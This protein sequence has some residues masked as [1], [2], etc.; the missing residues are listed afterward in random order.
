MPPKQKY[1]PGQ[2]VWETTLRCNLKC[3]HCGS[4]AGKA[5]PNELST[6]EAIRLC[7]DLAELDTKEVCLMGGE[8]FLRKDWHIIAKK[9][10][11][12]NMKL[13]V[14]SNGYNI[15][16]DIISKLVKLEPHSVSTSLDGSTAKTHDYIRGVNGS[17]DKVL[18]YISLSK[19]ADL[20]TTVITTVSKLNF[21]ELPEIRD[22]LLNKQ[23]AWQ[24]QVATPEGR[25]TGKNALSKEEYYSVALFIA[26]MKNKYSP[27]EIPVAAAH[28]FGY[29]SQHLPWLGLYPGWYG[30]QAGISVLS[31]KSN[32]DIIGCLSVPESEIE[33]NIRDRSIIE[34]WNDPKAFSYTRKFN[35]R[36]LGQNCKDCKYGVTC[37]GGCTGMSVGFT[38]KSH[39]HPYCFYK[40]EPELFQKIR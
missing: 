30:C 26:S 23:I 11:D 6:D 12:L 27:K 9:I 40:I 28:C 20:P 14:I 13:L 34:I 36:D 38:G 1:R 33:G 10:I 17:F 29:H 3:K 24:I 5:R 31:I 19:K 39:N 25:F 37:K 22:F 2:V 4:S 18:E 21:K 32:G 35:V 16:K 8:P 7:K 15:N